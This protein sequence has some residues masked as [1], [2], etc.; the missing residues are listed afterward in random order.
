M[1]DQPTPPALVLEVFLRLGRFLSCEAL[2]ALALPCLHGDVTPQHG[3]ALCCSLSVNVARTDTKARDQIGLRQ[4]PASACTG[5][6]EEDTGGMK[7]VFSLKITEM[8]CS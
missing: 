1:G 2:G 3:H 6:Q 8:S 5:L 7:Q 4:A